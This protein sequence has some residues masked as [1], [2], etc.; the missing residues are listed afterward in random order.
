MEAMEAAL[1]KELELRIAAEN[2]ISVSCKA[3]TLEGYA[4]LVH[5][6]GCTAAQPLI[7]PRPELHGNHLGSQPG[8]RH[9][10]KARSVVGD[11]YQPL[12]H[13]LAIV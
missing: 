12:V 1:V 10:R 7:A 13:W 5:L 6:A 3:S 4:V 8:R 9:V 11:G 2:P